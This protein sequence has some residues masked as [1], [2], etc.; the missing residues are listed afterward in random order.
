MNSGK[1]SIGIIIKRCAD[2]PRPKQ[3]QKIMINENTQVRL[4]IELQ[5]RLGAKASNSTSKRQRAKVLKAAKYGKIIPQKFKR[6]KEQHCYQTLNISPESV[7]FF[8]SDESRPLRT[9]PSTWKKA[10][11]EDRLK[12]NLQ[13]IADDIAKVDNASFSYELID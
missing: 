13:L 10:E 5:G 7:G 6:T 2:Y 9:S 4:N 12:A 1:K 8:I 3:F 11:K